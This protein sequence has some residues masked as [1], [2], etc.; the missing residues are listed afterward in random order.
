MHGA[1]VVAGKSW[2]GPP[3]KWLLILSMFGEHSYAGGTV[4]QV[5][6]FATQEQCMT[7]ARAWLEQA[8]AVKWPVTRQRALCVRSDAE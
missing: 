3:M 7:A 6:P 2:A 4:T 8:G 1:G 5:G